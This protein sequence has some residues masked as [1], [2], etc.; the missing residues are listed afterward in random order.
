[1]HANANGNLHIHVH[2]KHRHSFWSH[3]TSNSVVAPDVSMGVL[4][5]P[6]RCLIM[7]DRG[8]QPA[9]PESKLLKLLCEYPRTCQVE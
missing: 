1:M 8:G 5:I 6:E 4:G 3:F 9:S 7:K 2:R